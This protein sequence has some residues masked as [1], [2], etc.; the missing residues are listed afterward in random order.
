M[1]ARVVA[2]ERRADRA[3]HRRDAPDDELRRDRHGGEP[4]EQHDAHEAGATPIR[5]SRSM[6]SIRHTSPM[7]MENSGIVA[8]KMAAIA[9][10]MRGVAT[11]RPIRLPAT[12]V[13]PT[14]ASGR[15]DPNRSSRRVRR[16]Q[17]RE[18]GGDEAR[19][20]TPPAQPKACTT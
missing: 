10:P 18:A 3:E 13:A 5:L 8:M 19:K 4:D 12:V 15:H 17:Q 20:L 9:V 16:E 11:L 1:L 2:A 6:C 14:T 7:S